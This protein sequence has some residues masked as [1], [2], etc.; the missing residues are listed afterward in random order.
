MFSFDNRIKETV[1]DIINPFLGDTKELL[2][3]IGD[4]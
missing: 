2:R 3:Q 1:I 4:L